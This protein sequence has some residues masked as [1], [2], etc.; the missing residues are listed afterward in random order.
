MQ[1]QSLWN[2]RVG[3]LMGWLMVLMV[4]LTA[5]ESGAEGGPFPTLGPVSNI[6]GRQGRVVSE[7]TASTNC[8]EVGEVVTFTLHIRND[9]T[10]PITLTGPPF[11]EIVVQPVYQEGAPIQRW[12]ASEQYPAAI[13]PLFVP[14]EDRT[15]VWRWTADAAYA[16]NPTK[17]N[18]VEVIAPMGIL[19]PENSVIQSARNNFGLGIRTINL[20]QGSIPCIQMPRS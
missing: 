12:S 16:P 14:G 17:D 1:K 8:A 5:C 20:A 9:A 15:Y 10:F 18:G 19:G 13:N 3:G 6:G 2:R 7:L 11:L 4:L